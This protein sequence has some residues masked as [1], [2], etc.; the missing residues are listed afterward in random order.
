MRT[1]SPTR[2]ASMRESSSGRG[3]AFE[4]PR[5]VSGDP[6]RDEDE[7]LVD[8]PGL[9]ERCG[10]GRPAFEEHGLDAVGGELLE[11]LAERSRAELELGPFGQ[12]A[13]PE[14]DSPRLLDHGHIARVEAWVVG[15]HGAHPDRD[16]VGLCAEHVDEPPGVL[17]GDPT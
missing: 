1:S 5:P 10:E 11:L 6:R 13:T 14:R 3:S 4:H 7:Q 16:G 12:R 9:E 15:A 2:R 8:E 17:S